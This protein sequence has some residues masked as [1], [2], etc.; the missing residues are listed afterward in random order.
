MHKLKAEGFFLPNSESIGRLPNSIGK[1]SE[2]ARELFF[3][4]KLGLERLKTVKDPDLLYNSKFQKVLD[5]FT[6]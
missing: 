1:E 2:I 6:R 5:I 3:R 4:D